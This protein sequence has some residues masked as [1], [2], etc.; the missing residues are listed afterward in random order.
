MSL[1]KADTFHQPSS[2]S[3]SDDP[4][5]SIA[6]LSKRSTTYTRSSFASWLYNGRDAA[7]DVIADFEQTF[8]GARGSRP[9]VRR[10]SARE[11][12]D[13]ILDKAQH[14]ASS[15]VDSG[16]GSSIGSPSEKNLSRTLDKALDLAS[17]KDSAL[18]ESVAGSVTSES[19]I[20]GWL[21]RCL[22]ICR[23]GIDSSSADANKAPRPR[24]VRSSGPAPLTII[25]Y[26]ILSTKKSTQPLLSSFA[27][28]Q[29]YKRLFAPLLH[30]SRFEEFRPIVA[31][32][33]KNKNLRC[34][35][36]IEQS[37]INQPVVST[38][39]PVLTARS[40]SSRKTLTVTPSQYRS[41]GELTIQLV[42]DTY[43]HLSESEQRRPT[44]RAYENGYFLD[45]VQQVQQLAAHIGSSDTSVEDGTQP[46]VDDEITLEGGLTET[47]NLAELV[48]WKNGEGISLRTG[49]P[50]VPMAGMKRSASSAACDDAQLSA[51][52]KKG[53]EYPQLHLPC[54][55]DGCGKVFSRACDLAKHEKTHSR[56]YK[57][58]EPTCKFHVAG[59]PTEKEL[60]RHRNDKHN[61]KP[62]L[63]GCQFCEF[64]TKR[65]SNCK[66]HMEKKHNWVYT[67]S[68][69]KDKGSNLTPRST[70]QTPALGYPSVEQSP[71]TQTMGWDAQSMTSSMQ[72][73]PF[74]QPMNDFNFA[75]EY[76]NPLFPRRGM[77]TFN[78]SNQLDLSTNFGNNEQMNLTNVAGNTFEPAAYPTP[79]SV[80]Q[81]RFT[82]R[83]PAYSAITPSPM[84][85]ADNNVAN[86]GCNGADLPTPES[87]QSYS[88]HASFAQDV[89]PPAPTGM[90]MN[91]DL[92]LNNFDMTMDMN[93]AMVPDDFQLFTHGTGAF[94]REGAGNATLFPD[95][96]EF[97]ENRFTPDDFA[98]MDYTGF[99]A[100]PLFD[101]LV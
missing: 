20:Q 66:Q 68:K 13:Q 85:M 3:S 95:I 63:Y 33:R 34:L 9:A 7:V 26:P 81:Q 42:V 17:N 98:A 48:R 11:F 67:R 84:M 59:L 32:T 61:D 96:Q 73:S 88:R 45:L 44:D 43:Q 39:Y 65:E 93:D 30:E 51:R 54:P 78:Q 79:A 18:G 50:Y 49:L 80:V 36:D 89:A 87:N 40:N 47:G 24:P 25:R 62:T 92:A 97:P 53:V 27:R 82:P 64:K 60:D 5:V 21:N 29:I 99:E 83:T 86:Y 1:S 22:L 70:P 19:L 94:T 52:R 101:D 28:R 31:G 90:D 75:Q 4:V 69:G 72:E 41:F 58:P 71:L 76:P 37:L 46:T 16:L 35:R 55:L 56:P 23:T 77:S 12:E 6:H 100:D 10:R 8:S 14:R 74:Q 91:M 15:P 57:C 38:T 2:P